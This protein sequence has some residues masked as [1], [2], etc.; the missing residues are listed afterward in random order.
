MGA[1]GALI[2]S[3][4]LCSAGLSSECRGYS[5]IKDPIKQERKLKP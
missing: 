4:S 2:P 3:P 1:G 5:P